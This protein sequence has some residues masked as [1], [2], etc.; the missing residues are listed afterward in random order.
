MSEIV[1]GLEHTDQDTLITLLATLKNGYDA[2]RPSPFDW[3]PDE[4]LM[5]IIRMAINDLGDQ[6]HLVD[7]IAMISNRFKD[8]AADQ[9]L[10]KAPFDWLPDEMLMKII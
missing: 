9:S 10:W 3:L 2:R 8:L 1:N 6:R 5:K 7:N 4:M